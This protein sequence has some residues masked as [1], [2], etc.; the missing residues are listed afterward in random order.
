MQADAPSPSVALQKAR[1]LYWEDC[2]L[3]IRAENTLYRVSRELL[4]AHSPVFRDMFLLPMPVDAETYEGC[5]LVHLPDSASDV[6]NFFSALFLYDFFEAYPQPTSFPV[7]SSVLRLSDKYGVDG[8]RA[9]ALG[10][11]SAV[12]PTNLDDFKALPIAGNPL[13]DSLYDAGADVVAL[14]RRL[15]LDWLLPSAFYRLCQSH[16]HDLIFTAD[17]SIADK[18][19][20]LT[21]YRLLEGRENNALLEFL[22]TPERYIGCERDS[23]TCAEER[24]AYRKKTLEWGTLTTI[25]LLPNLP[26]DVWE[27]NDWNRLDVCD[28]CLESM[29][30]QFN[31]ARQAFWQKVPKIF[32]LPEWAVLEKMRATAM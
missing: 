17:L 24:M 10:H 5:P 29:K 22:W 28:V 2:G 31:N 12:H 26:L 25:E 21:G 13:V 15:S 16:I 6:S 30:E 11:L 19:R 1:G 27:E 7:V 18:Q 8:L 14:A 9:R 23:D 3:V 32:D 20:W 4:S